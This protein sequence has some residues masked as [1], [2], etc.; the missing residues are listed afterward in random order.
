VPLAPVGVTGQLPVPVP[1]VDLQV[2]DLRVVGLRVVDLQV[3]GL[4]PLVPGLVP[5]LGLGRH[6]RLELSQ[7][8]L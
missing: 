8:L 5:V 3:P 4:V 6:N 7:P 2:V 1:V